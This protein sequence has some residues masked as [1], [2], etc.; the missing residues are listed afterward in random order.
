M[1]T[2][3]ACSG[4]PALSGI[5]RRALLRQRLFDIQKALLDRSI[6]R[7]LHGEVDR[8]V[9]L[10]A[11]FGD[12]LRAKPLDQLPAHF[13]LEVLSVGLFRAQ[14]VVHLDSAPSTARSYSSRVIALLSSI[15]F[16][17]MPC[18]ASAF[19]ALTVGA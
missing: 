17:T 2:S 4:S 5:A 3:A 19:S 13:F 16:R 12:A 9:N 7:A 14:S 18:R 6:C 15:A 10:Q 11:A 1:A 8:G